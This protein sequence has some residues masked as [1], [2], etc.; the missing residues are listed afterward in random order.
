MLVDF[1]RLFC[2]SIHLVWF[3]CYLDSFQYIW[4]KF[5]TWQ[6]WFTLCILNMVN[7]HIRNCKGFHKLAKASNKQNWSVQLVWK[8][9]KPQ[10]IGHFDQ[11]PLNK[12][13]D[14]IIP[15]MRTSKIQNGRRVQKGMY[16]KVFGHSRQLSLIKFFDPSTPSMTLESF[17]ILP[18]NMAGL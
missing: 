6:I 12:L 10:V 14:S 2:F 18:R 7:W 16:P 5:P 1:M 15:S 3:S 17:R 11:L 13:F 8:Q 4:R 9:V